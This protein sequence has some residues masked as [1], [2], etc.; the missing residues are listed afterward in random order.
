MY[1]SSIPVPNSVINLEKNV[2]ESKIQAETLYQKQQGTLIVWSETDTCDLALSF[3]EKTGCTELWDKIC[4]IQGKDP[5]IEV[6]LFQQFYSFIVLNT[7]KQEDNDVDDQEPS[8][9]SASGVSNNTCTTLPTIPQ[10]TLQNLPDIE[11]VLA[12]N[13]FSATQRE[14]MANSIQKNGL[15]N[16][17][18]SN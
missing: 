9:S 7:T 14:K 1:G 10:C 16:S 6:C 2:L 18:N 3:Q 11:R 12:N 17:S 4:K 8:D 5:N 15:T 13:M